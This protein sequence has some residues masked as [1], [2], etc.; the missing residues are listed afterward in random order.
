MHNANPTHSSL[1]EHVLRPRRRAR[2]G[3]LLG[4][5]LVG[6]ESRVAL[7]SSLSGDQSRRVALS[8]AGVTLRVLS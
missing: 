5:V 2:R 8:R 3:D 4:G 7:V 1:A 6:D